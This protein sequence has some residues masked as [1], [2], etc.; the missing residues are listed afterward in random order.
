MLVLARLGFVRIGNTIF[1][2][3]NFKR[4]YLYEDSVTIIERNTENGSGWPAY[5]IEHIFCKK[6]QPKEYEKIMKIIESIP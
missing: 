1:N 6:K 5:D 4:I 3:R 2:P